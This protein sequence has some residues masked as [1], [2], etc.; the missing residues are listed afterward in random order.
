MI[1]LSGVRSSCDMLATNS[2]FSR[3]PSWMRRFSISS[4]CRRA[5]SSRACASRCDSSRRLCFVMSRAIF[6]APMTR[7]SGARMGETVSEMSI[8]RPHLSWR[9]VSKCST[10]KPARTCPSTN[11]SSL[12]PLRRNDARD[13]LP[14]HFVGRVAEHPLGGGV[15]RRD[16]AVQILADDRIVGRLARSRRAA[17]ARVSAGLRSRMSRAIFDAPITWPGL[18]ADGR[19]RQRHVDGLPSF[20]CKNRFEVRDRLAAPHALQ[21]GDLLIAPVGRKQHERGLPDRLLRPYSPS[22]RSAACSTT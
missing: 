8:G 16:D 15:P 18:V 14:D 11:V 1:E 3:L 2:P 5:A 12:E 20:V 19:D 21:R 9:I 22:S 4:T 17:A 6:E 7:P 13:R 10:R